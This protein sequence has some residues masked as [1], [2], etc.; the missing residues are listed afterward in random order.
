MFTGY[1]LSTVGFAGLTSRRE[2]TEKLLTRCQFEWKLAET[3]VLLLNN[4]AILH[5]IECVK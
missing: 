3:V 5:N 4:V 1:P 2:N